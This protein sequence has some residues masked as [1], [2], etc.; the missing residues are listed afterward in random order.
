MTTWKEEVPP[1]ILAKKMQW[2]E[3]EIEDLK[4]EIIHFYVKTFYPRGLTMISPSPNTAYDLTN[5]RI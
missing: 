2:T 5:I 3:Q 1:I 4:G